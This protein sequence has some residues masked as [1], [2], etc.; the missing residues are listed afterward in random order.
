M[1][2]TMYVEFLNETSNFKNSPLEPATQ[3]A[4]EK[5]IADED[6]FFETSKSLTLGIEWD[7]PVTIG[8]R[9]NTNGHHERAW[10]FTSNDIWGSQRE[11]TQAYLSSRWNFVFSDRWKLLLRGEVGYTDA[12]VH[13]FV[14]ETPDD[15]LSVSLTE[16]PFNYRFKAG[17]SRSVRGYGFET[18]STNNI[19][20][21]NILTASAELEFQFRQDW[22][23]AVFYDVGNAFNDWDNV[24]LKTGIGVG[25]RWYTIAGA[26]RVD[27]AQAQDKEGKPWELSLTIGTPLL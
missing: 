9:F 11:F 15:V 23:L 20:S 25:I 4:F 22:S 1:T 10:L 17:G 8:K 13:E 21:N 27:V 24:D 14:E 16:L 2:E 5:M 12:E 26:I 6:F 3:T 7:W 18:L 19:G